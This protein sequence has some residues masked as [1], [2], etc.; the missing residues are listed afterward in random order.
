MYYTVSFSPV[1]ED[2]RT[3]E[4]LGKKLKKNA[5]AVDVV[6][7]EL[8]N[9]EQNQKL[10]KFVEAVNSSDNRYTPIW[11]RNNFQSLR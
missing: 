11:A 1:V 6:N 2:E 7:L 9:P 8:A 4:A 5:V 3:L 10:Q